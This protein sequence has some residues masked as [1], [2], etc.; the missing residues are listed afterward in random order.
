MKVSVVS[1]ALCCCV[2]GTGLAQVPPS[3]PSQYQAAYTDVNT[4]LTSFGTTLSSVWNGATSPVSYAPQL[5]SAQSDL[6]TSLLQPNY[7]QYTVLS[8]LNSLQA[9]GA[10][11]VTFH[12]NFPAFLPSYYSNASDYQ[13]YASFYTTLMAELRSR[14][15]QVVIENMTAQAYPGTNGA[16]FTSYYQSLNWTNYMALRAQEA[17][18]IATVLKPDY[19][20]VEAEPDTEASGTFQPNVN[21]VS[22]ATQLVQGMITAVQSAGATSVKVVAGCGT[23]NPLFLQFIQS[24]VTLPLSTIDMHIYP[25]NN[26]NLPNALAAL[27]IIQGA[28]KQASIS[29]F[30]VYKESNSEYTSGLP[31]TTVYARDV[32]SFWGPTDVLFLQAMANFANYGKLAFIAPFWSHYF[33]AYLDYNTYGGQPD[34]TVIQD[35]SSAATAANMTG[36]FTSTGA[37]W[38]NLLIP[39]PDKT[40]PQVPAAP[41]LVAVSQTASSLSWGATTD[42]VGV[43]AYNLY[44]NGSLIGT[45][46]S[47][48][49][50]GDTG[51]SSNTKYTYT[52]SAFDAAGNTSPQSAPLSVTTFS[53]PDKTPPTTPTG[54]QALPFSDIQISLSWS[55]STD[56]VGVTG[57]EIYRGTTASSISAY[58]TSPTNSFMDM[59]TGP[60]KTYYYQVDAYD[61]ANNHSAR[62]AVVSVTTLADTTPPTTPPNF[63]VAVKSGPVANLSWGAASDDYIVGGYQVYRGT[64]STNMQLIWAGSSLTYSDTRITSGK[65]YYYA[66]AAVDA[67]KNVSAMSPCVGITAP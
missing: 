27:P 22:G 6:T 33:N 11:A 32:Y 5:L 30:W 47:P 35:E 65:G 4:S 54:V 3:I 64:S 40:A 66:V 26:N 10:K 24:F 15:M 9:L 45:V 21:T 36:V 52:L 1:A 60:S 41:S 16:S 42:N 25:V 13:A 2:V 49:V 55:P 20:V 57:Y 46:N 56:N 61:A 59:Q 48:L 23:W 67:S 37:A 39:S 63:S 28:G 19:M 62:S 43:A 29:E 18:N 44:R 31:Y 51:L 34:A 53:Y 12:V 7:Y 38:E 50:F 8:E 14:G 17:A 58:S